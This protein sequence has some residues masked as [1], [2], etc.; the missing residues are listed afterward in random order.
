LI[1]NAILEIEGMTLSYW[2]II[3]S[4][5]CFAN[6]LGLNI[7]SGLNSVVAIYVLI[8]LILVPHLLFSGVI[9]NYDKLHTSISSKEF[10]PR[11]GD[12]MITRWSYEALAVTQF[13]NNRYQRHFFEE[14]KAMS[15]SSYYGSTLIP[16]LIKLNDA[17]KWAS[18][19]NDASTVKN[20]AKHW[21]QHCNSFTRT[22]PIWCP[23]I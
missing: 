4:T 23:V 6:M 2:A 9:V 3:F 10:V 21:Q 19:R 11:I 5:A 1:G 14:E 22:F 13:K 8:P 7:S 16:E 15:Q 18:E 20:T 17:C 12:M